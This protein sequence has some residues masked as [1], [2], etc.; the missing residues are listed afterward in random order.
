MDEE[1]SLRRFG[2]HP[3]GAR[4]DEV[5]RLLGERTERERR[6][7]GEGDTELMRLCCVQLFNGG[8]LDDALLVWNAKEAGFDAA[9]SIEIELLL[10]RGLGPT[11]DHLAAHPA[12]SAAAALR[13]LCELEEAGAFEGFSVEEQS[14]GYARYYADEEE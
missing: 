11:K 4:L 3:T 12:P 5:R 14:A 6:A 10:G 2:L 13:R 1:E 9:C 8:D 7:Q